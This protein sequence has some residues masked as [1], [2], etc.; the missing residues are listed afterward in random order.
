ME[1]TTTEDSTQQTT[2][3]KQY[4]STLFLCTFASCLTDV[5]N[6]LLCLVELFPDRNQSF[7]FMSLQKTIIPFIPSTSQQIHKS[8][9]LLLPMAGSYYVHNIKKEKKGLMLE[10]LKDA[11]KNTQV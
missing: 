1:T 6:E 8:V 5:R 10:E 2:K 7:A 11:N 9:I 3:D 4:K